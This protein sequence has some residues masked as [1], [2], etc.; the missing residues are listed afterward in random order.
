MPFRETL[1]S[2]TLCLLSVEVRH[3]GLWYWRTGGCESFR[4]LTHL[5]PRSLLEWGGPWMGLACNSS[6][7]VSPPR[8]G[9]G[10]VIAPLIFSVGWT[11]T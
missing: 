2:L 11:Y 3:N 9:G 6:T 4:L 1:F 8:G 10:G 7:Q 5:N